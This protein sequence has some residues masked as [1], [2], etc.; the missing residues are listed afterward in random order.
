MAS[1]QDRLQLGQKRRPVESKRSWLRY[2]HN[3][4]IVKFSD[5]FDYNEPHFA[6]NRGESGRRVIIRVQFVNCSAKTYATYECKSR[7]SKC[8]NWWRL[9]W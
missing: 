8:L 5:S 1:C 2:Q 4:N 6:A 9:P 3:T 7:I